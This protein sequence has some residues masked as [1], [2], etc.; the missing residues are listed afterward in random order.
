MTKI[1]ATHPPSAL[2]KPQHMHDFNPHSSFLQQNTN[3]EMES[4][5]AEA[6]LR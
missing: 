5:S 1:M 2:Y 3:I 6:L 4:Q